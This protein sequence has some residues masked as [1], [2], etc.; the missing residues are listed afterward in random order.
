[1]IVSAPLLLMAQQ[2]RALLIGIG[3]YPVDLGWS[4]LSAKNDIEYLKSVLPLKGFDPTNTKVL[5]NE[6]ATKAGIEH[7]FSKLIAASGTG[8]IVMIHFSGHGQQ[9]TDDSTDEADGFDEAWIPVDAQARYMP[10]PRPTAPAY[11]GEFHLRDDQVGKWLDSLSLKVGKDG[12]ILVSIDACHS[13]TATRSASLGKVRGDPEPFKIPGKKNELIKAGIGDQNDFIG[14]DAM[15]RGNIVTFSAS[16][17]TQVNRETIDANEKGVGSL[18][19]A[20]SKALTDLPEGATYSDLFYRVKAMIQAWIP[21]QFPMMEGNGKQQVF[22]GKYSSSAEVTYVDRWAGDTAITIKMG[23]LQ[24]ISP[25]AEFILKDPQTGKQ[26]A[27]AVATKVSLVETMAKVSNPLDKMKLWAV[28]VK[29]IPVSPFRLKIGY[30]TKKVPANWIPM[31]DK[32]IAGYGF[33][34]KSDNPDCWITF[35]KDTGMVVV[36]KFDDMAY[37]DTKVANG[38]LDAAA[39]DALKKPLQSI[40]RTEFFRSLPDGGP[41]AGKAVLELKTKDGRKSN[42]NSLSFRNGEKFDFVL[43]NK[44]SKPFYYSIVVVAPNGDLQVLLPR[45]QD[46]PESWSLQPGATREIP[47]FVIEDIAAGRE[48]FRVIVTENPGFD[49]RPMFVKM[50]KKRAGLSS[51][52]QAMIEIMQP[53]PGSVPK[54]RSVQVNDVT[55]ITQSYQIIKE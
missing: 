3:D 26:V 53:E 20:L 31:L 30:D 10:T 14:G 18:T 5:L 47:D 39:L 7:A 4:T 23:S 38:K 46:T 24:E 13:G 33:T 28:E 2:K 52:E 42:D 6:Q 54:K 44:S 15:G 35:L 48:F 11:R 37:T 25:G 40:A 12:S 51:W 17:P 45:P 29:S 36:T 50:D 55:L 19:F 21:L 43:K 9:I 16:S 41:L 22:A 27:T 32:A 8:D 49:I 1:M 34:E